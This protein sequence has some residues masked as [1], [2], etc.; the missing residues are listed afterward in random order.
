MGNVIAFSDLPNYLNN[1][2]N[3]VPPELRATVLDTNIVISWMYD[4]RDDN[5][6]VTKILELLSKGGYR[7]FATVN[8][9][10][11]FLEFHRRLQLT[12]S[13]LS[14]VK[15]EAKFRVPTK[16]RA[17]LSSLRG[18]LNT[19][20]KAEPGRDFVFNDS[21]LKKIKKEF[22]A[23]DHSGKMGWLEVCDI[24]LK[25]YLHT[26]EK[27]LDDAGVE[28]ISQHKSSQADL[29]HTLIDWPDAMSISEKS[30]VSFSDS[31]ILNAF[32]C[33]RCPFIVSMDFDVGY[34]VL[35]D[36][37]MKDAVMPDGIANE[38][39]HYHFGSL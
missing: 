8:T 4:Q 3:K 7:F 19:S 5:K 28:Y 37:K 11:E 20:V 36:P 26:L 16:A 12:E 9:K 6:A 2:A 22:S 27:E 33:S 31:M 38:F 14:F 1:L 17:L 13:L 39:R 23:G 35:S 25:G 21:H 34:A 24:F 29:F 10:S 18:T 15:E 32:E 30:G